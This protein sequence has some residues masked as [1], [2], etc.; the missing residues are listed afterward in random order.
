MTV[1]S[2][3]VRNMW[4]WVVLDIQSRFHLLVAAIHL[5]QDVLRDMEISYSAPCGKTYDK[6]AWPSQRIL[7]IGPMHGGYAGKVFRVAW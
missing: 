6:E 4:L 7:A 5:V 3:D 2:C 1:G